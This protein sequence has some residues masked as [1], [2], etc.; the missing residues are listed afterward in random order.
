[1]VQCY[2]CGR[3]VRIGKGL[4]AHL[5]KQHK[6]VTLAEYEKMCPRRKP[7]DVSQHVVLTADL[8][9]AQVHKSLTGRWPDWYD[10]QMPVAFEGAAQLAEV[11]FSGFVAHK[12]EVAAEVRLMALLYAQ[13]LLDPAV[14]ATAARN[15]RTRERIERGFGLLDRLEG[16]YLMDVHAVFAQIKHK[17][18][19][20]MAGSPAGPARARIIAAELTQGNID[21]RDDKAVDK[22]DAN[23]QKEIRAQLG[24][25][26]NRMQGILFGGDHHLQKPPSTVE[27][28]KKDSKSA[29]P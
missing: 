12:I 20:M 1:M 14:A 6:Q 16:R 17:A 2:L 5:V 9:Q 10:D 8:Y 3:I 19:G 7:F 21:G 23:R 29:T 24:E 25:I 26:S 13:C 18:E 4:A 15:K 11:L 22:L 28:A 27:K